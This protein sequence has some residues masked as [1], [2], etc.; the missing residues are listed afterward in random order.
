MIWVFFLFVPGG[1]WTVFEDELLHQQTFAA[2]SYL[3][4]IILGSAGSQPQQ[5]WATNRDLNSDG[6]QQPQCQFEQRWIGRQWT[7]HWRPGSK[8]ARTKCLHQTRSVSS[9]SIS[10]CVV[11]PWF[12]L[13][14][15]ESRLPH[16]VCPA[17]VFRSFGYLSMK[18]GYSYNCYIN[19]PSSY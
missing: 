18:K 10:V 13:K 17:N 11:C 2:E 7:A 12:F 5:S 6:V 16:T 8:V 15:T 3:S 1:K 19:M 4:Q 14:T 9:L